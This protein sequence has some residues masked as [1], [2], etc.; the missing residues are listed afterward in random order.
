[1]SER[2][3]RLKEQKDVLDARI[4]QIRAK[5]KMKERKL[6]TRRKIVVGA[7]ILSKMDKDP[8]FEQQVLSKLE[9]TLRREIDR[10]LFDFPKLQESP[11][12]EY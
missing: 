5:E 7:F 10:E 4:Q 2:L 1:M 3:Q 12:G 6:D 9:K 11:T 8:A